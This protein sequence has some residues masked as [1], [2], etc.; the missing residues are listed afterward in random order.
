[1]KIIYIQAL[2]SSKEFNYGRG[3]EIHSESC[4]VLVGN[5][6]LIF[7]SEK[8]KKQVSVIYPWGVY[9]IQTL[10]FPFWSGSCHFNNNTVYLCFDLHAQLKCRMRYDMKKNIT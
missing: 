6:M 8:T 7:G 4:A 1:M 9:L 2:S 5:R 10:D 3:T